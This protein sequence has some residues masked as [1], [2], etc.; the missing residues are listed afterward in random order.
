MKSLVISSSAGSSSSASSSLIVRPVTVI[1]SPWKWPPSSS[2]RIMTGTPPSSWRSFI[3]LVPPGCKL[4]IFGVRR[5]IASNSSIV[6][7]TPASAASANRCSTAFVDPPIATCNAIAFS[8][9]FFESISD[10]RRSS[11]TAW[12][13]ASPARAAMSYR[14]C[15]SAGASALPNGANPSASEI[16]AIVLAVNMPPHEPA[17]GQACRSKSSNS[18]ADI[19]PSANVPTPS[20]TF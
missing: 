5:E 11:L 15:D 8:K 17:P 1:A 12:R 9:D 3:V 16:E 20:K 7:S 14:S 6:R 2:R 19:C 10:G 4:A 18:S 13:T